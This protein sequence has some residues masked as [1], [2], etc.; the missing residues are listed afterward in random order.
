MIVRQS[1]QMIFRRNHVRRTGSLINSR[2]MLFVAA[3]AIVHA[4]I[5]PP[6]SIAQI[7]FHGQGSGSFLK[8]GDGSSQYAVDNGRGTFLWRGDLFTDAIVDDDIALHSTVRVEQDQIFHVD[9]FSIA[10]SNITPMD[11]EI[12]IGQ[13]E[14]PIGNLGERRFPFKNPFLQLPLA[15]EH[16]TSLRSTDLQLWPY[17]S[18]YT[19]SGIGMRLLDQ[20]LYDLGAKISGSA[21]IM[22]YSFTLI[23]GTPGSSSNYNN[24]GLSTTAK[25]GKI[26][27]L[28]FTPM[29]GL[30]LGISYADGQAT[31]NSYISG[32]QATSYDA[33]SL[34]QRVIEGDIS[35]GI[36]YFTLY[37]QELYSIW[38]AGDNIGDNLT[39]FSYSVEGTYAVTARTSISGRVGGIL[40]NTITAEIPVTYSGYTTNIQY[41]GLWD[42]N[43]VRL[44][45]AVG[46]RISRSSIAKFVYE[47]NGTGGQ[48][49][50]RFLQLAAFQIVLSF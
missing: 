43:V 22:D 41:A 36:G 18:R 49:A 23:N 39:A 27:R 6:G 17:D 33:P 45:G 15:N 25:P 34:T 9:L 12:D 2:S 48:S 32:Y 29:I 28:A 1:L 46:Y 31:P 24:R 42:Q 13:I 40:F 11:L 30:T 26:A 3:V 44:E 16:Y 50:N 21:G 47:W 4:G 8:S 20:S 14:I 19:S 35:V 38:D 37:T 5:L 7:L 10:I